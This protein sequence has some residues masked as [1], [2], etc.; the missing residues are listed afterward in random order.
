M[1]N[2]T[3]VVLAASVIAAVYSPHLARIIGAFFNKNRN[4]DEN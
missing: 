2:D 4:K 3:L 1:T